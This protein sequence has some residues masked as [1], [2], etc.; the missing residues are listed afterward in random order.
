[1][2]YIL[3]DELHF[4]YSDTG[5]GTPFVFQHGLGADLTQPVELFAPR[6]PFRLIAFDCRAHGKTYP[7][8]PIEKIGIASSAEDL[9]GILDALK[10]QRAVI[11]GVSM[12]AAIALNF[13]LRF[14]ERLMGL[15]LS[16]P[17]W[18]DTPNPWNVKMF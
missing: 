14:P 4:N 5:S 16:R 15:V 17:A 12:G 3:H 13:A 7:V 2:P 18:L 10:V 6:P 1:M 8:G 9:R 11:G